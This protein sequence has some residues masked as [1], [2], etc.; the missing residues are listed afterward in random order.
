MSKRSKQSGPGD[1]ALKATGQQ[2][3]QGGKFGVSVRHAPPDPKR[4]TQ[5][6]E[7]EPTCTTAAAAAQGPTS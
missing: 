2:I 4:Q 1:E 6:G 5:K 7:A 3:S